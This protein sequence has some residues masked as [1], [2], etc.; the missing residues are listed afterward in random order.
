MASVTNY[1]GFTSDFE[2]KR[3]IQ[4]MDST[5]V[6][7]AL[8][9]TTTVN[10]VAYQSENVIRNRGN[11][12][13]KE[14][15]LLSIWILGMFNPSPNTIIILPHDVMTKNARVTTDYFGKIPGA[16]C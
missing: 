9:I 8:G 10:F 11:Y 12:W 16:G 14:T 7:K 4:L 13:K 1:H 2:I 5:A 3:R 6:L 15:G